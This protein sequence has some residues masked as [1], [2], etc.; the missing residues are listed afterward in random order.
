MSNYTFKGQVKKSDVQAAF[1]SFVTKINDIVTTYNTTDTVLDNIDLTVG[2]ETLGAA[3]YTLTVGGIK[4]VLS[5]YNGTLLGCRAFRI[6]STKVVVTDGL[7]I[8]TGKPIRINSQV[9]TGSGNYISIDRDTGTL[10]YSNTIPSGNDVIVYLSNVSEDEYL[11]TIKDVYL[12][13]LDGYYITIGKS[14]IPQS[15]ADDNTDIDRFN[16][17]GVYWVDSSGADT[18]TFNNT[19]V[20]SRGW[21]Y[22]GGDAYRGHANALPANF[23][24]IPKGVT[25]PIKF[26]GS[27]H[28]S[29][30]LY[31]MKL[32]KDT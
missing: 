6:S 32:N 30:T 16:G 3:G 19:E 11:S 4:Q 18:V 27:H 9:L 7:Y 28:T 2:G 25:S 31:K 24:F 26:A 12:E 20:L 8:T 14:E 15:I 1:D 5:A 29:R 17:A 23:L 22:N 13:G 21:A 10:T